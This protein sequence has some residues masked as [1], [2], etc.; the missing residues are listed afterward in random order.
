[1]APSGYDGTTYDGTTNIPEPRH[2]LRGYRN[3]EVIDDFM[4]ARGYMARARISR[5]DLH[6]LVEEG[7]RIFD[8]ENIRHDRTIFVGRYFLNE[9]MA[10]ERDFSMYFKQNMRSRQMGEERVI[11]EIFGCKVILIDEPHSCFVQARI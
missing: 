7:L 10:R 8:R 9:M 5:P 6:C 2:R 1:M 4:R 11:G 3:V